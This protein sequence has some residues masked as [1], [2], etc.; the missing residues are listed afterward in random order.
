MKAAGMEPRPAER[1]G[2]A[3]ARQGDRGQR[4]T[5]SGAPLKP[6]AL[7]PFPRR[8][9]ISNFSATAASTSGSPMALISVAVETDATH[10]VWASSPRLRMRTGRQRSHGGRMFTPSHFR[11]AVGPGPSCVAW[12]RG[13]CRGGFAPRVGGSRSSAAPAA[14]PVPSRPVRS[15]SVR[16][17]VRPAAL[18]ASRSCADGSGSAVTS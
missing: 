5:R 9:F 18:R 8:L 2:G 7:T 6:S 13:G 1:K 11:P 16:P 17:S 3:A 12:L 10:S 15:R 4:R 14:R